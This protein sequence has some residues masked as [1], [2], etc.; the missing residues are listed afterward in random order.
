MTLAEVYCRYNR[1]RTTQLV[2]PDDLKRATKA[3]GRLRLKVH[4]HKFESGV[5]VLKADDL[6][7]EAVT[8][9][10]ADMLKAGG[11]LAAG[12]LAG[13]AGYAWPLNS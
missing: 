4:T 5:V 3:M 7:D 1:A 8:L 13:Y 6:G 9:R 12:F 11:R 2:A 10:I